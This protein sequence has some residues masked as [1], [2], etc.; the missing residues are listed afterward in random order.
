MV[1]S[2]T[3]D[4]TDLRTF[5]PVLAQ[6][7]TNLS[8]SGVQQGLGIAWPLMIQFAGW[9]IQGIG[10][11]LSAYEAIWGA[12]EALPP[13][14]ELGPGDVR[15]IAQQIAAA[16]PQ[17]RPVSQW[18]ALLNQ[19]LQPP[20]VTPTA[21]VTCPPGFYR[22]AATGACLQATK[23]GFQMPTWGWIALGVGGLLFVTKTGII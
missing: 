12:K 15:A 23:A 7:R 19:A 3:E 22:D 20:P 18:E 16:D 4:G 9:V 1:I 2:R 6:R 10:L 21:P 5:L 11:G 13:D 17:H 14:Q 8:L